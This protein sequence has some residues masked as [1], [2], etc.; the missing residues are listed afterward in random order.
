ML[1]TAIGLMLCAFIAIV[2]AMRKRA[3]SNVFRVFIV[4][5]GFKINN[6]V[7]YVSLCAVCVCLCEW[8][9]L[10]LRRACCSVFCFVIDVE[11]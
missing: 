3:A 1:R 9:L 4:V 5:W 8:Q 2:P 10:A 6:R 7:M 11:E